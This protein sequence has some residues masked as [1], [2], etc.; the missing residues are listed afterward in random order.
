MHIRLILDI[1]DHGDL[2]VAL[3]DFVD[4]FADAD[5]DRVGE[6]EGWDLDFARLGPASFVLKHASLV[7]QFTGRAAENFAWSQYD[8]T[9]STR[10]SYSVHKS[11]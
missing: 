6:V 1:G 4:A 3:L 10:H 8:S 11:I 2:H 5:H 7:L 9:L